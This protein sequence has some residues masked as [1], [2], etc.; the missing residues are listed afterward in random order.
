MMGEHRARRCQSNYYCQQNKC[1]PHSNTSRNPDRIRSQ[2]LQSRKLGHQANRNQM[3]LSCQSAQSIQV[4]TKHSQEEL[5]KP[6][7]IADEQSGQP[8]AAALTPVWVSAS[9]RS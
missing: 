7:S 6:Q 5:H 9:L 4:T 3:S 2:F 1:I 8:W